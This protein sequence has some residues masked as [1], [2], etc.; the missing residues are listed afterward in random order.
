MAKTYSLPTTFVG[1]VNQT[2]MPEVYAVSDILVLPSY[3]ETWGLVVNEAF[4]CGLPA[5]VSDR[6]GCAPD[7]VMD[8]LTGSTVPAGDVGRLADAIDYW[9]DNRDNATTRQALSE[10]NVRYSPTNSAVGFVS[11]AASGSYPPMDRRR[12]SMVLVGSENFP[13][14]PAP[15]EQRYRNYIKIPIVVWG[16]VFLTAFLIAFTSSDALLTFSCIAIVPVLATLMWRVGEPPVA[17]I[18]VMGQW[19]QIGSGTFHATANGVALNELFGDRGRGLRH[20]AQ[21]GW[22]SCACS[23]NSLGE[24]QQTPDG[25]PN[26]PRRA[27]VVSILACVCGLLYRTSSEPHFP[28]SDLEFSLALLKLLLAATQLRWVFFFV[29]VITTLVR[30]RGYSYLIAATLFEILLGFTSFFSDF[31]YVFFVFAVS[32]LMVQARMSA[33]MA[34]SLA[35]L[36]CALVFLAIVWS[37][38]KTD[39]RAI[40][41]IKV[42][43]RR[44]LRL[45]HSTGLKSSVS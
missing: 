45:D 43:A 32:Y 18:A 37:V 28:R 26:A 15:S 19:L 38:I 2:R 33:R 4:A 17:F 20:L 36:S 12:K 10:A 5:I 23:R 41:K 25:Y 29:L 9:I 8:G 21:S 35:V 40:F 3:S 14:R 39:Y 27:P 22:T 11:A 42:L 16:L 44:Y 31:R 13:W 34:S 24:F 6:V 30:K 1:F 7:L